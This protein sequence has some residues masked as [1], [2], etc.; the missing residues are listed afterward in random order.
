MKFCIK[1]SRVYFAFI[2][3]HF[4]VFS[5]KFDISIKQVFPLTIFGS[6]FF[7]CA[8][9]VC[10]QQKLKSLF[11]RYSSTSQSFIIVY[12][13]VLQIFKHTIYSKSFNMSR[14]I[15][16]AFLYLCC[17]LYSSSSNQNNNLP[18]DL[19]SNKN[20][21]PILLDDTSISLSEK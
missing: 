8:N 9:Y 13:S 14:F 1:N 3:S 4:T 11:T 6:I 18:S 16:S 21:G 10:R 15:L 17:A 20:S 2:S 19:Q 12:L 7:L 5:A